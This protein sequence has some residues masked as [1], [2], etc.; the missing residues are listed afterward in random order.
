[1]PP[2]RPSAGRPKGRLPPARKLIT[3]RV[4]SLVNE[5]HL[6]NLSEAARHTGLPYGTVR[7][8]FLGRTTTPGLDTLVVLARAYDLT[9]NW[10]ID[11]TSNERPGMALETSLPP[12]PEYRRGSEGRR[13]TIPLA[14][15]PL[16][17]LILLF[18]DYLPTLPASPDRPLIGAQND[19]ARIRQTLVVFLLRPLMD[20]Q[21]FGYTRVLGADP[22]FRGTERADEAQ[23][24]AWV[25]T[26][27]ALGSFWERALSDLIGAAE[28]VR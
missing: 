14:A 21:R 19:R 15:W 18:E 17:R 23:R 7:D 20:G 4:R 10:F 22:P 8:L 25:A 3:R 6:G 9:P 11:Q 28:A 1:M 2:N 27:R 12:D 24:A 26:L 5:A 16:A 13:F